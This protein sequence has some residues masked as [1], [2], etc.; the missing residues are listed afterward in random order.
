M[1]WGKKESPLRFVD[2]WNPFSSKVP[3][4]IFAS[5]IL[6]RRKKVVDPRMTIENVVSEFEKAIVDFW[7]Q[8]G[9]IQQVILIITMSFNR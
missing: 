8:N 3:N 1:T 9:Q 6:V 4:T 2:R 5:H 7:K